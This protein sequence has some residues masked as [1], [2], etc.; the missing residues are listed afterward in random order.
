MP[1]PPDELVLKMSLCIAYYGLILRFSDKQES[2]FAERA[3]IQPI[4]E[5]GAALPGWGVL[6]SRVNI[7]SVPQEITG[8]FG[9]FWPQPEEHWAATR[10]CGRHW[11]SWMCYSWENLCVE[12]QLP[13]KYT[14]NA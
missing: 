14:D 2:L 11:D 8:Y 9:S 13:T 12:L 7:R 5:D 3:N 4:W 10:V 1:E 6:P